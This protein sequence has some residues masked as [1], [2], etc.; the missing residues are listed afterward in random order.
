MLRSPRRVQFVAELIIV[1]D[2]I[3][4]GL[5]SADPIEI[6][7]SKSQRRTQTEIRHAEQSG[8]QSAG[9]EI[10]RD[11]ERFET[12]RPVVRFRSI[13]AR[14]QS[15]AGIGKRRGDVARCNPPAR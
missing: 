3:G 7:S 9:R 13:E 12:A 2:I 5:K 1:G 4:D 11:G 10:G 6:R 8:H 14:D 15:D